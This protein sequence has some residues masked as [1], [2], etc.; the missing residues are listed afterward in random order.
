MVTATALF[1]SLSTSEALWWALPGALLAGL[2]AHAVGSRGGDGGM[3]RLVLAGAV[4]SAVLNAYVQ[5]VS[6]SMPEVFDTYRYWVV[7][8]LA[9]R[10]LDVAVT[11]L[12]VVAAATV[13]ALL[14][15]GG[16]NALALGEEAAVSTGANTVLVR[17]CALVAATVL[18]AAAT[19]AVGPIAFVGLA[20][21]HIVRGLVGV[22]FRLQAPF[23]LLVGP[24]LLLLSDVVGR[25]IARPIELMVGVVTAFVGAP[26]LLYV[27]RRMRGTA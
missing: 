15:T 3:A 11:V 9:G 7:G 18:A 27:V 17:A 25:T 24:T 20:V 4:V 19:A 14:A 6:L 23:A 13:A 8:S 22:D 10:D 26:V 1:G 16:L 12:P 5:A 21:P 2:T